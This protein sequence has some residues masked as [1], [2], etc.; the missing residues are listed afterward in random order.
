MGRGKKFHHK[1]EREVQLI[2]KYVYSGRNENN[3]ARFETRS[4]D[5]DPILPPHSG[6]ISTN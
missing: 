6:A 3:R 5:P 4:P 2:R 1:R